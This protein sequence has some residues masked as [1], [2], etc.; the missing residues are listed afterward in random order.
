MTTPGESIAYLTDFRLDAASEERLVAMLEGC[1]TIVCENNFRNAELESAVRTFHMVSADVARLAARIEPEKLILFHLSD[2]YTQA[3][4]Q[5]QLE[6][7]RA[8]FAESNFPESWRFFDWQCRGFIPEDKQTGRKFTPRPSFSV[9]AG[10]RFT[11][12]RRRKIRRPGIKWRFSA[13]YR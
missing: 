2:R 11:G 6:E 12:Y 1:T 3:E 9:L 4:W 13:S 5:D 10:P 8:V 7:V